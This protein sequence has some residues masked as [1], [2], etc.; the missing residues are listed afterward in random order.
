MIDPRMPGW[1]RFTRVGKRARRPTSTPVGEPTSAR[2]TE[3]AERPAGSP[4]LALSTVLALAACAGAGSE[5]G[6]DAR[7]AAAR[8]DQARTVFAVRSDLPGPVTVHALA[9][10]LVVRLGTV[11]VGREALWPV[12]P[13]MV[14]RGRIVQL[15][16]R[17]VGASRSVTTEAFAVGE[18]DRVYWRLTHPLPSSI[19]SL[20][21]RMHR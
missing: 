1:V 15:R 17:P 14:D 10:G 18:G 4:I 11:A 20:R 7:A 3:R 2:A 16:A 8:P 5:P 19:A 21:V 9:G 6:A 13:Q 12:P